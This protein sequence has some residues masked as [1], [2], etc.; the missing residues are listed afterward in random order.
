M[1]KHKP[2]LV[3]LRRDL[4]LTDHPALYDAAMC[5]SPVIPVYILAPEDEGDWNTGYAAKWW[6]KRSLQ[7]LNRSLA[8][9]DSK[10]VVRRG[11]SISVLCSL[12]EETGAESVVWNR[13]EDPEAGELELRLHKTLN[14]KGIITKSFDSSGLFGIDE[15]LKDDGHPYKIFTPFWRKLKTLGNPALP[16]PVIDRIESPE[17]WPRS[18]SFDEVD[19]SVGLDIRE[20]FPQLWAPGEKGAHYSLKIFLKSGFDSYALNRDRPELIGTSQLSPHISFGEISP[21]ILWEAVS[22]KYSSSACSSKFL[23]ELGWREFARHLLHH[24]PKTPNESLR[25][26]FNRFPWRNDRT[27]LDA[28]KSGR[29][30][31]PFVDAGM[32]QLLSYGWINNRVRM[33]T[34]SFLVKHLMLPWQEGARW[35]WQRLVDADLA[36]NTMGW[37][38]VSGSGADAAPYFRIFNPVIQGEKFDSQG[39]YVRRWIPEISRLPDRWIHKP[40]LAPVEVLHQSGIRLGLDYPHPI[41]DHAS[42]RLRAMA[43]FRSIR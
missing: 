30:G 39:T 23:N 9:L 19:N 1:R 40:W 41:V 24:F 12:V 37:Q 43:A 7:A 35:F 14:S 28:W 29:T 5:D 6:L 36:S 2:T 17:V 25:P 3:W 26:E 32:R 11:P 38:W 27:S 13:S 18:I 16:L 10:L 33:V 22:R 42:S 34:A 15:V 20:T 31:Y 8:P 21:R 4:R